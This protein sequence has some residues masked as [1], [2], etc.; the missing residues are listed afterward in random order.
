MT[1][2]P[3]GSNGWVDV[4]DVAQAVLLSLKGNFDGQRYI[5]SAENAPY[6]TIFEKIAKQLK[7][8]AP[9]H[10]LSPFIGNV[11]QKV[12]TLRSFVTQK[13]PLLTKETLKSTSVT[14]VY[15]NSKSRLQLGL[16]YRPIDITIQESCQTFLESWPQPKTWATIL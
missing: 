5:I 11:I 3:E 7:V 6:K 4:R 8:K 16:Q 12:E 10:A 2:Y 13:P 15:D 1:F 14:S 9:K